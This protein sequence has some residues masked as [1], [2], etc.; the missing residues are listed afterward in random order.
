[1]SVQVS[2]LTLLK[3]SGIPGLTTS[4]SLLGLSPGSASLS[5]AL[6]SW[7]LEA[8]SSLQ[9]LPHLRGFLPPS[10]AA[11]DHKGSNHTLSDS[12]L[13]LPVPPDIG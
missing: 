4:P 12:E 1:M 10:A 9:D 7:L 5:S 8:Q 11:E 2:S 3:Q 6:V 13:L